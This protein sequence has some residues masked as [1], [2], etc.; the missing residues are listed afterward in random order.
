MAWSLSVCRSITDMQRIVS[1]I[2]DHVCDH[3][4]YEDK[5]TLLKHKNI[6]SADA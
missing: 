5:H 2:H 3:I 4:S 1:R 6:W